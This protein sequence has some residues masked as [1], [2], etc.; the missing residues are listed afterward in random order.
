MTSLKK[1]TLNFLSKKDDKTVLKESGGGATS[2]KNFSGLVIVDN[3]DVEV[4]GFD[5]ML[6]FSENHA[7]FTSTK[8]HCEMAGEGIEYCWGF[9][10][11][12]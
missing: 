6:L 9:S 8:Y 10:K 2:A 3:E 7:V 12:T 5:K 1:Q 11:K 4:E